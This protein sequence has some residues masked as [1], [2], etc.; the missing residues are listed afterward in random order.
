MC[1]SEEKQRGE[2]ERRDHDDDEDEDDNDDDDDDYDRDDDDGQCTPRVIIRKGS[3]R[4]VLWTLGFGFQ[5]P[6]ALSTPHEFNRSRASCCNGSHSCSACGP[7]RRSA[8]SQPAH[9]WSLRCR[10][11]SG[12]WVPQGDSLTWMLSRYLHLP[13]VMGPR[14]NRGILTL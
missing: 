6:V 10:G 4:P 9:L 12:T 13:P 2:P 8:G 5:V 3:A 11:E 7:G 14:Q 1:V